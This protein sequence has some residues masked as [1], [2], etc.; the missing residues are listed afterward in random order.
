M[1]YVAGAYSNNPEHNMQKAEQASIQLIKN[2]FA[3]FTPHKNFYDYQKYKDIHYETYLR[4]D[5]EIIRRCDAVYVLDNWEESPGTK[6]E[7]DLCNEWDIPVFWQHQINE[8]D[9]MPE[10][11]ER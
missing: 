8:C 11:I 3:V 4:M 5:F 7:I 10:M 6:R 9:F 2:G 1:V